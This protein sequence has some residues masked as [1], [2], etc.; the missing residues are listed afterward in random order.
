[1]LSM[2]LLSVTTEIMNEFCWGTFCHYNSYLLSW[3]CS[4]GIQSD[5]PSD[6]C[7]QILC[8][9]LSL[10]WAGPLFL[11]PSVTLKMISTAFWSLP[12]GFFK[13]KSRAQLCGPIKWHDLLPSENTTGRLKEKRKNFTYILKKKPWKISS[14]VNKEQHEFKAESRI[15]IWKLIKHL[16]QLLMKFYLQIWVK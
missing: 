10:L 2:W 16:I 3:F 4:S 9:Y 13:Q 12:F 1:M 7:K 8:F 14:L 15:Y 5:N 6:T 11:F